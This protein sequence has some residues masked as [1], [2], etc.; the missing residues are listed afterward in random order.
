M[1]DG[2]LEPRYNIGHR[3]HVLFSQEAV[4]FIAKLHFDSAIPN[5]ANPEVD[6]AVVY[7][8]KFA[9]EIHNILLWPQTVLPR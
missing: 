5:P 2:P 7:L 8:L 1:R 4:R 3:P 9:A 6:F